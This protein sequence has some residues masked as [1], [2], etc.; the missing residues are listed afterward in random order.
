M[1]TLSTSLFE[2]RD[3]EDAGRG[4]IA[5]RKISAGTSLLN[6]QRPIAH[7]LFREYRKEV[8]GQCFHYDRGRTLNIRAHDI[9]KVFCSR[10]CYDVWLSAAGDA[11][12]K[13]WQNLESFV[14][15]NSKNLSKVPDADQ[16]NARPTIEQTKEE[17]TMVE[18]T[19][20]A[21]MA[22]G[23]RRPKQKQGVARP[24][25]MAD[26]D[27]LS[28]LLSAVIA[29]H[30]QPDVWKEELL[31]LAMD[32]VPY[33]TMHELQAHCTSFTQLKDIIPEE[34]AASISVNTC[35]TIAGAA[36]HN[37][38]GIRSGSD[39][40][41]E[42]MGYGVW[43]TASFFNH[44]CH[45]NVRKQRVC[46]EWQFFAAE[47]VEPGQQLCISYLGGDERD[48]HVN[49]RRLR[50]LHTWGFMC[51]CFRC[52]SEAAEQTARYRCRST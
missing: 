51:N 30:Q 37:A 45:P 49:E 36:S 19:A 18:T 2:L 1:Q 20:A 3:I 27:V 50:L 16:L 52:V 26:P 32:E 21:N 12:L 31:A 11:G 14:R 15:T 17:W 28:F 44:A 41:E 8:C 22:P 23:D 43:T 29:H 33:T 39:D 5:T 38:F 48:M 47:D 40:N 35:Q 25:V 7:V 4:L 6:C 24:G 13:A 42:Y 46:Q 9:G 34:M 10:E